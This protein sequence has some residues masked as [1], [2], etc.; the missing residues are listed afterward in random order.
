MCMADTSKFC[1]GHLMWIQSGRPDNF[2][3]QILINSKVKIIFFFSYFC[4]GIL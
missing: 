2:Y 1:E 3:C 4:P